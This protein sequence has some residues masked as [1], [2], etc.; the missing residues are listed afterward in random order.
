M[1]V[2]FNNNSKLFM[3]IFT[4]KL[5]APTLP[6]GPELLHY[7]TFGPAQPTSAS[8]K[9]LPGI[10]QPWPAR[11]QPPANPLTLAGS[12]PNVGP[13]RGPD[14]QLHVPAGDRGPVP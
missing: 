1:P 13:I 10:P 11:G 7:A 8:P 6:S 12:E 4:N 5:G 3:P 2:Y 9:T 14:R